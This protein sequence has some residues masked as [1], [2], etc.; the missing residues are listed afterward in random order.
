MSR[1]ALGPA[2]KFQPGADQDGAHNPAAGAEEL[3][4]VPKRAQSAAHAFQ[5]GSRMHGQTH[6]PTK[7]RIAIMAEGRSSQATSADVL[8]ATG[9]SQP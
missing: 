4:A 3:P 7:A 8:H 9:S 2:E 1:V 5:N 6:K